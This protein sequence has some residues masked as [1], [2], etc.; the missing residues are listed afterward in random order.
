MT[1]VNIFF[2]YAHEDE[3]LLNKL[4]THLIPLYR[5]GL[6]ELLWHDRNISA[7][8]E[9]ELEIDTY[10]NK[11]QIIVLLVSP[12][13]MASDYCYGV[14]VKRAIERHDQ[15]EARVIPVI[16]RYAQWKKS[17]IGKLQALPTDGKPVKSWQDEDEAFFNVVEG[18]RKA[19]EELAVQSHVPTFASSTDVLEAVPNISVSANEPGQQLTVIDAAP[20]KVSPSEVD[21][22]PQN[23]SIAEPIEV[24]SSRQLAEK[25][26]DLQE[27]LNMYRSRLAEMEETLELGATSQFTND[28]AVEL[29]KLLREI[30]STIRNMTQEASYSRSIE[31]FKSRDDVLENLRQ[32]RIQVMMAINS[33]PSFLWRSILDQSKPETFYQCL[34][35]CRE[36]LERT[37]NHW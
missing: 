19:I 36:Y 25:K 20:N 23:I 18:I 29:H 4:K 13:F 6:I 27:V 15:K 31:Y 33:L 16:L 10:L 1:P 8:K 17:P 12:D 30:I 7:G 11:A 5:E 34:L 21:T 9:W 26:P 24:T 28:F 35:S 3:A 37:L 2:S 22:I 32:A 14:E